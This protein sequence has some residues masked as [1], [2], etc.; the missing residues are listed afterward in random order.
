MIPIAKQFCSDVGCPVIPQKAIYPQ[1]AE[2]APF[3]QELGSPG[4]L[5]GIYFIP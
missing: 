4:R 1:G 2:F 5:N 3:P